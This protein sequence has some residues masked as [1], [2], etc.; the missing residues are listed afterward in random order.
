MKCFKLTLEDWYPS[1]KLDSWYKGKERGSNLLEVSLL[2]LITGEHR[3]CVWGNDDF[4]MEKDFPT[5]K[6]EDALQ[7][8]LLILKQE[9]VYKSFLKNLGFQ[10]A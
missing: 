8:Y 2:K 9:Y 6:Y 7:D 4:G 10:A 3:V 5:D 1:Y